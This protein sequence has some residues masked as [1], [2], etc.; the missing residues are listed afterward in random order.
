MFQ[1]LDFFLHHK[2]WSYLLS[3]LLPKY[4]SASFGSGRAWP[5]AWKIFFL[6]I[7]MTV[8]FYINNNVKGFLLSREGKEAFQSN[9]LCFM[10]QLLVRT[11]LDFVTG[12]WT[13]GKGSHLWSIWLISVVRRKETNLQ[14]VSNTVENIFWLEIVSINA[15]RMLSSINQHYLFPPKAVWIETLSKSSTF[16]T[17]WISTQQKV[18]NRKQ[19][20]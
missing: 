1:T 12:R 20:S 4:Q 18:A 16:L 8:F 14:S 17:A 2:P 13:E 6:I 3:R 19:S 5:S 15:K 11:S 9:F 10:K 7:N